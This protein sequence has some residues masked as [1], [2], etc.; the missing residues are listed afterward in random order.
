MTET[1]QKML[2]IIE[3]WANSAVSNKRSGASVYDPYNAEELADVLIKAGIGDVVEL[4]DKW[5]EMLKTQAEKTL[6]AEH[7]AEVYERALELMARGECAFDS[8]E[9]YKEQ[10]EKELAEE[11]KDE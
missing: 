2:S 5:R 1:K 9:Y 4:T 11:R 10:A 7:R 6:E 8:P 3:A